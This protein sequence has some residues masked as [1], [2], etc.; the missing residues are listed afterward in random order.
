MAGV[1]ELGEIIVV[2]GKE[3]DGFELTDEAGI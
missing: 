1:A 2:I 3:R